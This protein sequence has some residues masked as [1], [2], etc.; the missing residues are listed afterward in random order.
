MA[1][2]ESSITSIK[3]IVPEELSE[4]GNRAWKVVTPPASEP[5]TAAQ[6]K[7]FGRIDGTD[8]DDLINDLI[9]SVR[10]STEL[11]LGRSLIEQTI[12]MLMDYWPETYFVELP[13]PPLMA[14][15]SIALLT[16]AGSV[17]AY[18]SANYF[19]V[20]EA[21]P[22]QIVTKN[23]CTPPTNTDRYQ[24]GIRIEYKA[25]YGS[26]AANI[27]QAILTAM[28]LWAVACYEER[29]AIA[30]PPPSALPLLN[31]FKVVKV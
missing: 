23:G 22:G 8:E 13:A 16:Q 1:F 20:T 14:V 4:K 21:I 25:G 28:K 3:K 19:V 26:L 30:S 31:I 5:L 6:V 24:A 9:K 27:P 17:I 18:D 29:A 15:N 2:F 7:L 11:Y 12:Q 10:E